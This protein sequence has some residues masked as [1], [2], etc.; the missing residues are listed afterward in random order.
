MADSGWPLSQCTTRSTDPSSPPRGKRRSTPSARA[1]LRE[2]WLALQT[3][4]VATAMA[5]PAKNALMQQNIRRS[6]TTV[7]T[8]SCKDDGCDRGAKGGVLQ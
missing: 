7:M 6:S 8:P 4:S 1:R 5:I 3:G 2:D